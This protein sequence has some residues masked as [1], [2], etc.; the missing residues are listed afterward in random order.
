MKRLRVESSSDPCR[1]L[2]SAVASAVHTPI[3]NQIDRCDDAGEHAHHL[4]ERF[5]QATVKQAQ[6]IATPQDRMNWW[7]SIYQKI[8][9]LPAL[10][11]TEQIRQEMILAAQHDSRCLERTGME[12]VTRTLFVRS[13]HDSRE[14]EYEV[15]FQWNNR[16]FWIRYDSDLHYMALGRKNVIGFLRIDR[17]SIDLNWPEWCTFRQEI[18]LSD[19]HAVIGARLLH[20]LSFLFASNCNGLPTLFQQD[21]CFHGSTRTNRPAPDMAVP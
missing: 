13:K 16:P 15:Q 5:Q 3:E 2:N 12:E 8:S 7:R 9:Q 19:Q 6:P 11:W 21:F 4:L 18:G 17:R 1:L 10:L 20:W 14:D